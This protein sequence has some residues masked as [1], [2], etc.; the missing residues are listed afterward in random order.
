MLPTL[1]VWPWVKVPS[2]LP[3]KTTTALALRM[4]TAK[5]ILPSPLKSPGERDVGV[6]AQVGVEGGLG[7]G[8]VAVAREEARGFRRRCW[9]G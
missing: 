8:A 6:L 4:L 5:S 7:K 2:P 1:T 3:R 9:R